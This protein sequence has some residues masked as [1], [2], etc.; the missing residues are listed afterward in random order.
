MEPMTI[1]E[2]VYYGTDTGNF[3]N[4]VTKDGMGIEFYEKWVAIS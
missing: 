1:P 2:G 3:Y 4:E